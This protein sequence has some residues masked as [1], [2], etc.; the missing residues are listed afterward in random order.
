MRVPFFRAVCAAVLFQGSLLL[1]APA[2]ALADDAI[3]ASVKADPAIHALLPKAIQ[4][5][6]VIKLGTDAHWPPCESFAEDG[7][8]MV[9]WEPD[10]WDGIGKKLGV[11]V[12]PT[13]I[14][15]DGLLPGVESGRFDVA[16]ECISDTLEREKKFMFVDISVA[17]DVVFALEGSSISADPLSL[18]GLKAGVQK[19]T[20]FAMSMDNILDPL[21]LKNG[22]P[23]IVKNIFPTIDAVTLALSSGRVDFM[24]N[25][26]SAQADMKKKVPNSKMYVLDVLPKNFQGFVLKP[27]STELAAA[28]LAATKALI[29]DGIY[30]R[31]FDKWD[32]EAVKLKEP[33]INLTST[34]AK[35]K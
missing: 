33:G 13:S 28:L 8:T 29:A 18:C 14:D 26:A 12:K 7:V 34:G 19:G 3:T 16:L 5:S 23:A 32:L 27:E 15:F 22:K 31:I 4:A 2:A 10:L 20:S 1:V 24:S 30:D 11:K 25:D 9:G 35:P 6:G 21:C 17:T